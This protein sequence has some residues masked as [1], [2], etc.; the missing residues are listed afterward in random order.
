MV[1]DVSKFGAILVSR[2]AGRDAALAAFSF[3]V[4]SGDKE[5]VEL[6]F[7][8]VSVMAPSWLDEFVTGLKEKYG[9]TRVKCLQCSNPSVIESLKFISNV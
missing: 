4:L 7:S 1:L 9:S 5:A 3:I 2:P 6:D 8:K